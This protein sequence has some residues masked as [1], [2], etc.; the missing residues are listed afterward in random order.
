MRI[1][2]IEI[3]NYRLLENTS[4]DLENELSLIV[5]KNNTGKTSC[6]SCIRKFL[7]TKNDFKYDD[8][9][10]KFQQEVIQTLNKNLKIEEYKE[11][12]I[13][14]KIHI[15]YTEKD[16]LKNIS[17]LLMDLD[18]NNNLLVLQF[19]YVLSYDDYK[20]IIEDYNIFKQTVK[21]KEI[22][23]YL[24][25]Y[26]KNYF[27]IVRKTL[28]SDQNNDY[29]IIDDI[30]KIISIEYISA[31]RDVQSNEYNTSA[32]K[33]LSKLSYKYFDNV[34]DLERFQITDLK[35]ELFKMDEQLTNIYEK[36][37]SPIVKNISKFSYGSE[38]NLK[39]ISR[40]EENNIL[41][42]NTNV[43][44][45]NEG[46]NLPED[47]NGLGY[48]NLFAIMFQIHIALDKLKSKNNLNSKSDINLLFIEEPEVHT[49]PQMQYIFIRNI[50]KLIKDYK[51][52]MELQTVVTTHSPYIVSQSDF[53]DIKYFHR[54]E[55]NKIEIK[56]LKDLEVIYNP[57]KDDESRKRFEFIKKY[58][59]TNKSELFFADKAIFIEGD[60]ERIL[61]PIM[62]KKIDKEKCINEQYIPLLSQNISIIEVGAYSHV[63]DK[64]IHFLG[65]K[66]LIITDIDFTKEE[67]KEDKNGREI[68]RYVKCEKE[69]ATNISNAAIKKFLNTDQLEC[70]LKH[71]QIVSKDKKG[72]WCEDI[73]G[74]VYVSFQREENGNWARSFE[75]AFIST[76]ID[77]IVSNKD[78]FVSLQN[79]NRIQKTSKNYFEI[80]Q[81]CIKKKSDFATDILYNT[82]EKLNNWEIPRYIKKG[83]EWIS[84]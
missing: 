22:D 39:V 79:A 77:F 45:E 25:N 74:Q 28:G 40:L 8:F 35:K 7:G 81:N 66:T 78:K 38:C 83:L 37:F 60:T 75:D 13:S 53:E 11:L 64:L 71:K 80:A 54:I 12:K 31:K 10:L 82:N 47:Y 5:G 43:M 17:D 18:E 3:S 23:F 14:M 70:V 62:M 63:F 4:L 58:L 48:M 1:K 46:C 24:R 69:E 29:K 67:E 20:K 49:H 42:D 68:I 6:I 73:N 51:E 76:N 16:N 9:N 59:T 65:I 26:Y 33:T 72:C 57:K 32:D 2:T 21:D 84:E 50:K 44:Y 19:E 15:E 55:R 61:L 41:K 56:N 52:D 34:N 30:S 27:K 36:T